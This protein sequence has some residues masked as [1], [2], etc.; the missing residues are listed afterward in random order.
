LGVPFPVGKTATR[1]EIVSE[2]IKQLFH[3]LFLRKSLINAD[4]PASPRL[5]AA[6]QLY[7]LIGWIEIVGNPEN[8]LCT[9]LKALNMS[10]V[11]SF[12]FGYVAGAG[13]FGGVLDF[14]GMFRFSRYYLQTAV[15]VAENIQDPYAIG[16]SYLCMAN[17]Q[18]C[19]GNLEVSTRNAIVGAKGFEKAG[20]RHN[21]SFIEHILADYLYYQGKFAESMQASRKI[22]ERGIDSVDPQIQCWGLMAQGGVLRRSG[23]IGEAV[24]VLEETI[25]LAEALPDYG[26]RVEAGG[27]LGRCYLRQGWLADTDTILR[28]TYQ[29]YLDHVVSWGTDV[30]LFNGL[31]ESSLVHLEQCSQEE[32]SVWEKKA[33]QACQEAVAHAR[34]FRPALP[35]ALRMQG[36]YEWLNGR[37][38]VSQKYWDEALK[39]AEKQVQPYDAGTVHYEVGYRSRDRQRLKMAESL[40]AE[41]GAQWDLEQTQK[42]MSKL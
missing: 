30:Q 17:H 20:D 24:K 16:M 34:K 5:V 32:R 10:E 4:Q 8:L 40:F 42:A 12:P 15:A 9:A 27:E 38:A 6:V 29:V 2:L 25:R 39:L 23:E 18:G 13:S 36:I 31:A 7:I 19:Q 33:G 26:D 11:G 21:Q 1:L 14:I 41:I 3:R 28:T 35:D 22:L 37:S